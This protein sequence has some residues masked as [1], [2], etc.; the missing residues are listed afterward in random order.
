MALRDASQLS[1]DRYETGL[2]TYLEM[3]IADQQ[4]FQTELQLAQTRG[5]Q[6]RVVRRALS[7]ARRRLAA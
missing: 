6:L 7:R 1:R 3:L 5:E 2:S 4:L